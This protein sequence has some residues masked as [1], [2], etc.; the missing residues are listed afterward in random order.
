MENKVSQSGEA[1]PRFPTEGLAFYMRLSRSDG[2][3]GVDDK[4][5]S[6]SIEN[7]R[8]L[9]EEYIA[10][11]CYGRPKRRN[12]ERPHIPYLEYVD[13]G[14]SGS[15]FERPSFKRMVEDCKKGMVKMILVK[16]LSRLGRDY[17]TVGDYIEQIF[18]MLGVR[19]I[20]VNDDFDSAKSVDGTLGFGMAIENLV[21]TLY[22]RDC[23]KKRM[24][25]VRTKWKQGIYTGTR[26]PFGYK[27]EN[28]QWYP[29]GD[30]AE[31]VKL[32]FSL[33]CSGHNTSGIVDTLNG[34]NKPTP[35]KYRMLTGANYCGN[36][37]CPEE[38]QLWTTSMVW[39]IIRN[40][41]YTGTLVQGKYRN[42]MLGTPSQRTTKEEERYY[43][44]NSHEALV[45]EEDFEKAQLVI[46]R[47]GR[48]IRSYGA[49]W[50]LKSKIRCGNCRR[51]M[52]YHENVG[53]RV[54]F[55][56]HRATDGSHST[57][58]RENF[59]Y[60]SI[61]GAV[62]NAIRN[63]AVLADDL[64]EKLETKY[65][66]KLDPA[67]LRTRYDILKA[68]Q[69]RLYETYTDGFITKD[70]FIDRKTE[71][72]SEIKSLEEQIKNVEEEDKRVSSMITRLKA[73]SETGGTGWKQ[74]T[75]K[76]VNALIDNVYVYEGQE[77]EIIFKAEDVIA[78]AIE[79]RGLVLKDE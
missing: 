66:D 33:A 21:N 76:V 32:I 40:E 50:V 51:R 7:Q 67:A 2:D 12:Q 48:S 73:V 43:T 22:Y 60:D 79:E 29:D 59:S 68:E 70:E 47:V 56:E 77:I 19:F 30:A 52:A 78:S 64:V 27:L 36:I 46:G 17:I 9:L 28:R 6:Y 74:L 8:L 4:T 72:A 42:V 63:M 1:A 10:N 75:R 34:L 62:R 65:S 14:Y 31:T 35:Y 23:I 25:S 13:D 71:M 39:R 18:P 20:S 38:K 3:L 58:P 15:N 55:C 54:V 45:S 16:D 69:I 57:C 26:V 53:E 24:S 49:D 37:V 61:E 11:A 44:K 5:E 41:A